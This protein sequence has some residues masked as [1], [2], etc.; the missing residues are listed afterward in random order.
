MLAELASVTL[1]RGLGGYNFADGSF[2]GQVSEDSYMFLNSK[3]SSTS[4]GLQ[5]S[6]NVKGRKTLAVFG[7]GWEGLTLW[8]L[9][10]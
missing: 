6:S 7:F 2:R 9:D 5:N 3:N 8:G 10:S 4:Q 1:F